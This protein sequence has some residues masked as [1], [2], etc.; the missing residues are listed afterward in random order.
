MTDV[1]YPYVVKDHNSKTAVVIREGRKYIF[2]VAMK[3]GR[4]TV[5]KVTPKQYERAGYV[6]VPTE[7]G[8]VIKRYLGHSAGLT[9][10]AVRE[11]EGAL[12]CLEQS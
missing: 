5:T 11:L 12:K 6:V 3:S 9:D 8:A 2:L 4:L 7:V 1:S 10:T